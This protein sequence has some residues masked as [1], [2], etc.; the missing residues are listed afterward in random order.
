[1]VYQRAISVTLGVC[2]DVCLC[3]SQMSMPTR[4]IERQTT[5][6]CTSGGVLARTKGA[7]GVARAQGK[8]E[9]LGASQSEDLCRSKSHY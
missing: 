4:N 2:M 1:M 9:K 8:P 5:C 6:I 7:T 3:L